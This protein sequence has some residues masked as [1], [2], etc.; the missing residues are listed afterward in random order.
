MSP[1]SWWLD[2]RKWREDNLSSWEGMGIPGENG[3][4]PFQ[5]ECLD[6][7]RSVVDVAESRVEGIEEKYVT[8]PLGKGD[9]Q[10]FIYEDGAGIHGGK[11]DIR[12]ERWDYR[13]LNDLIEAFVSKAK[14]Y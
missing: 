5:E 10:F 8:G 11:T 7:L 1:L 13:T 14:K 12:L 2:G 9:V 4:N 3:L 6:R